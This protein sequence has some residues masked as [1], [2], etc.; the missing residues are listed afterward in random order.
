M[1]NFPITHE[2]KTYWIAR[3]MAVSC[4]VFTLFAGKWCILANKRGKGVPD[5]AGYWNVPCGYLDYDE[6]T[7]EAA[8]REVYEETGVKVSRVTFW[9]FNDLPSEN[10]QNVTFRYYGFVSDPQFMA[11]SANSKNRGGESNEVER[12]E[13]IPIDT[14][15]NYEWAFNHKFLIK[16]LA[17]DLKL[18]DTL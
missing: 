6:T 12:A 17:F 2:G 11:L 15:D 9:N 3:N 8:K 18:C 16:T 4:F 5:Y 14:L 10:L 7:A 1:N 13:W